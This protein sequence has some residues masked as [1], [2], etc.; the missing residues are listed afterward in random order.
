M[1]EITGAVQ[2]PHTLVKF[3]VRST[4]SD[5][6]LGTWPIKFYDRDEGKNEVASQVV[7]RI[8]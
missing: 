7:E 6:I 3:D 1:E 2:S 4:G 8:I 5:E